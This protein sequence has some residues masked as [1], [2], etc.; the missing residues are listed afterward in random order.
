M[1]DF[2]III[3]TA[4]TTTTKILDDV[5]DFS[6]SICCGFSSYFFIQ[7]FCRSVFLFLSLSVCWRACSSQFH[8]C[9]FAPFFWPDRAC[10][11]TLFVS[12]SFVPILLCVFYVQSQL[13]LSE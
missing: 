8:A 12:L 1:Q 4:I 9:I 6:A 5:A 7:S 3:I 13:N 11:P 10:K 2:I